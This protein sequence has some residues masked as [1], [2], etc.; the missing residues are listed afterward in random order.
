MAGAMAAKA[1]NLTVPALL[2]KY[3]LLP[4]NLTHSYWTDFV[5]PG[6]TIHPN[7]H[8]AAAMISTGD[9]YEK[10]LQAVL[11]YSLVPK[12]ILDVMEEDAY[13]FYPGLQASCRPR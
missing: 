7:P 6:K 2:D 13:R 12:A 10:I 5:N 3:L 9:D 8:L 4:L 1:A 11:T